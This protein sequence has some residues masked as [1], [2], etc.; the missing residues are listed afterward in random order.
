VLSVECDSDD[1]FFK[2]VQHATW[3]VPTHTVHPRAHSDTDVCTHGAAYEC[4]HCCSVG[5]TNARPNGVANESAN[6]PPNRS[7]D[8]STDSSTHGTHSSTFCG[9]NT[10][11]HRVANPSA[12]HNTHNRADCRAD[13]GANRC[14]N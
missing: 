5:V 10:P 13:D 6:V 9:A 2:S 12:N 3:R 4:A 11:S 1:I 14:A 8:S 7:T